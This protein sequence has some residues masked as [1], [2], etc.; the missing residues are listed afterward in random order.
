M[1]NKA[2]KF[3]LREHL[4]ENC[5]GY[6]CDTVLKW[7]NARQSWVVS[8]RGNLSMGGYNYEQTELQALLT[9]N[10]W[11]IAPRLAENR[12]AARFAAWQEKYKNVSSILYRVPFCP[13]NK[14]EFIV[15]KA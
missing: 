13:E 7:D 9:V 1:L 3:I 12:N 14:L 5:R 11:Q 2:R 6:S 10:G 8:G 4:V 15:E